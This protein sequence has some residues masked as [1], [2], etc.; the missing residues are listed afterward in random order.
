MKRGLTDWT[1]YG[2]IGLSWVFLTAMLLYAGY[3][4]GQ[5]LDARWQT[6]PIFLVVG[7]M[8]AVVLSLVTLVQEIRAVSTAFGR[9]PGA[10]E[11]QEEEPPSPRS[12][13][14]PRRK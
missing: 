3:R 12:R 5:W 14:P 10:P 6:E 9:R 13:R 7:L 11:G 8:V 4:G 1:H 2:G